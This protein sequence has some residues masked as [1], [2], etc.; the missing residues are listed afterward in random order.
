[1]ATTLTSLVNLALRR[2][3]SG[4]RINNITDSNP[5]AVLAAELWPSVRDTVLRD[6]EWSVAIARK[7]LAALSDEN[8]TPYDY[9]Y[10]LPEEPYCLRVLNLID[11]ENETYEELRPEAVSYI[12][13][14]RALCTD[15]NPCGIRYI[16]R[17]EDVSLYDPILVEAM[18]LKLGAEMAPQM[19][20]SPEIEGKLLQLYQMT[21]M[22]A[23]GWDSE[24][25]WEGYRTRSSWDKVRLPG[26]VV[27]DYFNNPR[28]GGSFGS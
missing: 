1:M 12:I 28:R 4:E 2:M 18:S 3:G 13:E 24:E 27:D 23:K 6:H 7:Q 14:G 9:R 16:K 19:A 21:L 20:Q 26:R 22:Q 25:K 15:I 5:R 10:Q 11:V 17:V 8:L